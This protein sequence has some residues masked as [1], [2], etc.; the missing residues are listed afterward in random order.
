MPSCIPRARHDE[1]RQKRTMSLCPVGG[2]A[3]SAT[4][5]VAPG[6]TMC[7]QAPQ[8][9][10][11]AL[12][13]E[14]SEAATVKELAAEPGDSSHASLPRREAQPTATAYHMREP[15]MGGAGAL[16]RDGL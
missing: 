15:L 16:R 8:L 10:K 6:A 11:D 14:R 4:R 3:R 7:T 5:T 12:P 13:S 9:E 2:R 1:H